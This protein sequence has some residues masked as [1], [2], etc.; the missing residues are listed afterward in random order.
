M[1]LYDEF[2]LDPNDSCQE[3]GIQL[4]A[5]EV[6]LLQ[7]GHA[8]S[9]AL[10]KRI[11]IA[12]GVLAHQENRLLYDNSL[13]SLRE[14][15]DYE[16]EYL[17]NF[18]SWPLIIPPQQSAAGQRP[19]PFSTPG[20]ASQPPR[21]TSAPGNP[22]GTQTPPMQ[23]QH[24]PQQQFAPQPFAQPF[25]QQPAPVPAPVPAPAV[26]ISA[27]QSPYPF[28]ATSGTRLG[29]TLLD[30]F[31]ALGLTGIITENSN[32]GFLGTSAVSAVIVLGYF[33]AL[34]VLLGG[35][36]AK[37][38]FGYTVRDVH[39]GNKLSWEQSAKRNWWRLATLVPVIGQV[40]SFIGAIACYSTI[41]DANGRMGSHD[42]L[43]GAEVVK[44]NQ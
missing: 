11:R 9:S 19:N 32:L 18:G 30:G 15:S 2:R 38:M 3:L 13:K 36:P 33:L 6:R 26:P 25:Q 7:M 8:E 35:T 42:R 40:I 44:R 41:T 1:S 14:R 5:Q 23:Q 10:I 27:Y 17:A 39:T 43:A 21:P 20:P 24:Y 34:E 16:L 29:M 4:S 31:I 37:L 12:F 28:R 22:F